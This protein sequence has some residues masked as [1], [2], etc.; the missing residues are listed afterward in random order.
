[1]KNVQKQNQEE[2]KGSLQKR[3]LWGS[4]TLSFVAIV[5]SLLAIL[6]IQKGARSLDEVTEISQRVVMKGGSSDMDVSRQI[7]L[8]QTEAVRS[9]KA[10]TALLMGLIIG[11]PAVSWL[12]SRT[13]RRAVVAPVTECVCFVDDVCK[14]GFPE[15]LPADRNDEIGLL[16]RKL[17][18]LGLYSPPLA[19]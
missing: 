9:N 8:C 3:I 19:A 13:S 15:R 16:A 2:P 1:M 18:P 10:A 6:M 11:A 12:L 4:F 7:E 17:N 5:V 14:G